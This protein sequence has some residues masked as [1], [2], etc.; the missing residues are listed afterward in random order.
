MS[1]IGVT[2]MSGTVKGIVDNVVKAEQYGI[3]NAW[4]TAGGMTTDSLTAFAVAASKTSSISMGTCIVQTYLR[5][6]LALAI[7]SISINSL[8]PGRF[9]LGV[10]PSHGPSMKNVWGFAFDRPLHNTREYVTVLDQA[11]QKGEVDFDG[12]FFNVHAKIGEPSKVPVMISALQRGSFVLAGER[13]DGAIT[14]VT[15]LHYVVNTA[16]PAMQEG[17]DS[18]GRK[19][20]PV[21]LHV[22]MAVSEDA[23]AVRDAARTQLAIYPNLP[24]YRKMLV[25]AGYPEAEEGKW[26]DAMLDA[27]VLHGNEAT[28]KEKL[29]AI[30]AQ[31]IDEVIAMP[32]AVA[33]EKAAS[34]DR[35]WRF[36]GGL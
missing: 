18:A 12:D 25:A 21:I 20:P 34:I 17:A 16:I 32:L 15:P 36:I 28:V 26:S 4:C 33:P 19:R 22:P 3:K 27:V 29:D 14:W 31:G 1:A 6:P 13:T 9:R 30:Y 8:A 11:L 7:Q 2:V 5:H 24:F 23:A 35:T 10:G